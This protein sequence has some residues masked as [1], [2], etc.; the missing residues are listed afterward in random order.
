M[1]ETEL[2]TQILAGFPGQSKPCIITTADEVMVSLV[3]FIYW[4]VGFAK[5]TE[6][7]STKG[8]NDLGFVGNKNKQRVSAV[9]QRTEFNGG[10]VSV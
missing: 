3:P 2:K 1:R 7:I 9:F 10:S 5:T 8:S 4:S 6:R